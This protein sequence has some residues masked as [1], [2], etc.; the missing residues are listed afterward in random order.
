M[1]EETLD[2]EFWVDDA[3]VGAV[4]M[5][6]MGVAGVL[7][8]TELGSELIVGKIY[9]DEVIDL[10][11]NDMKIDGGSK[12]MMRKELMNMMFKEGG[13]IMITIQRRW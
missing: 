8:S 4:V 11:D 3:E 6:V 9:E 10:G 13:M 12:A 2:W 1:P 7:L 5:G